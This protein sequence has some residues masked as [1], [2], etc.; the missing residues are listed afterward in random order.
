MDLTNSTKL[1]STD[2]QES[3]NRDGIQDIT[4]SKES[5]L[6]G[7]L[8]FF[9]GNFRF[10]SL[11]AQSSLGQIVGS[12]RPSSAFNSVISKIATFSDFFVLHFLMDRQSPL[13]SRQLQSSPLRPVCISMGD[14]KVELQTRL[15]TS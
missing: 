5:I 12:Q 1:V 11:F 6:N 3:S 15:T 7:K 2:I 10:Y 14:S 4:E 13:R 8:S 9:P